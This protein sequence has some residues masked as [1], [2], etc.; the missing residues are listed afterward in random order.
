[1]RTNIIILS[2]LLFFISSTSWAETPWEVYLNNPT[3]D[4]AI[5][6]NRV[7]YTTGEIPRNYGYW[8]PDLHILRNQVMGGDAE[9]FRLAFRI[10]RNSDGG[11][12][13]ELTAI[14]SHSIRSHPQFFL[15]QMSDLKPN[16]TELRRILT[17]PGLEYVDH[18]QA[19]I[20]ELEMRRKALASV[21]TK[22]LL[23]LRVRCLGLMKQDRR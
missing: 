17:M 21:S 16:E 10:L 12:R 5:R 14:L 15:A 7:E 11:L 8:E 1:M 9:A 18:D 23:P 2:A 3:S 4:N 19:R 13:E 20:Y 22:A 6:V